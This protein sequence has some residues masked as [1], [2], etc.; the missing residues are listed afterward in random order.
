MRKVSISRLINN[1][2]VLFK[3]VFV[4][5]VDFYMMDKVIDK[6][7]FTFKCRLGLYDVDVRAYFGNKIINEPLYMLYDKTTYT[8]IHQTLLNEVVNEKS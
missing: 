1:P 8:A 2:T 6:S 5:D 3:K 4:W 7:N